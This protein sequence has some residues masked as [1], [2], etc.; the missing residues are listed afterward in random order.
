MPKP[1][2]KKIGEE[3]YE[4]Y[5]FI[6]GR[7]YRR[8][9]TKRN[10]NNPKQA[11]A[12]YARKLQQLGRLYTR[13]E[14]LAPIDDYMRRYLSWADKNKARTTVYMDRN[15][16]NIFKGWAEKQDIIYLSDIDYSVMDAFKSWYLENRGYNPNN[17][18]S[19][20][21]AMLTLA[22][23]DNLLPKNAL[24]GYK[25]IKVKSDR[26]LR[27]FT[28]KEVRLI[29]DNLQK[30]FPHN[31]FLLLLYTGMRINELI[32]L[33]LEDI[34]IGSKIITVESRMDHPTKDRETRY[35]PMTKEVRSVVSC[36]TSNVDDN[37]MYLF[38]NGKGQIKYRY[39]W[40]I[41]FFKQFCEEIG[42]RKKKA[43]IHLFRHTFATRLLEKGVKLYRVS[44]WLGHSDYRTTLKTYG[45]FDP[46]NRD[47]INKLDF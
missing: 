14:P 32:N 2:V 9:F 4:V 39:N 13:N 7:Q 19:L 40:Y 5:A 30:P 37:C 12:L 41:R 1:K 43:K 15:R 11:A 26:A 34:D 35:I 8:R 21:H 47:D 3:K 24:A 36:E 23:K 28:T 38:D 33:R 44:E 45:H 46:D 18:I 31:F 29:L 16:L 27:F 20:I 25:K 22:V 6:A 17:Y 42:I 10:C